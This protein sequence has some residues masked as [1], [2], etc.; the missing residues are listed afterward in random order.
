LNAANLQGVNV[1]LASF[2][3]IE[4][5]RCILLSVCFAACYTT[6]ITCVTWQFCSKWCK[7]ECKF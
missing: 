1:Q 5:S 3:I 7:A 2:I 4:F 6:W